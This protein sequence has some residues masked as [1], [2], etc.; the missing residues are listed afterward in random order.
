[1]IAR[2]VV[3]W[4]SAQ[5][6]STAVDAVA[7]NDSSHARRRRRIVGLSFACLALVPACGSSTTSATSSGGTMSSSSGAA[8][9]TIPSGTTSAPVAETPP[10]SCSAIPVTLI[11]PYIGGVATTQSLAAPPQ[12]VSCEFLNA[13]ASSIV[14][15]NIGAGGTAA[16]FATLRAGSGQ[17]GRTTTSISDLGSSAFSISQNGVPGGVDVLTAQGLVFSVAARLSLAQDEAL[18]RQLMTLY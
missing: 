11:S 5:Y 14:I 1:M 4:S 2:S 18:I 3:L 8:S 13:N 16:N 17:G 9:A 12:H 7:R 6:S 10:T 15:V